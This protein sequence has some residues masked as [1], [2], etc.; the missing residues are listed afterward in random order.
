MTMP[1]TPEEYSQKS[2][3]PRTSL[4][5][6][7]WIL[8]E[9]LQRRDEK[10]ARIYVGSL[11]ILES[12]NANKLPF[13][14]HGI[15]E[16][17]T[18]LPL[19]LDVEQTAHNQSLMTRV[20]IIED[21]WKRATSKSDCHSNDSWNGN[22]NPQ[23]RKFMQKMRDF[24]NWMETHM[25]RRRLEVA[26]TL[27]ALDPAR[28]RLPSKLEAQNVEIWISMRDFFIG[29]AHHGLETSEEDFR[30]RLDEFERF[31]IERLSPRTFDD[32]TELDDVISAG[33]S[34]G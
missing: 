28:G 30:R 3:Y 29:V 26:D 2:D 17:L 24:F 16:I 11:Q 14:A 15:R 8:Y 19:C 12:S 9:S 21:E 27:F 22:T 10:I 33:E 34:N 5:E 23:L 1:S 13:A 32:A 7:Q 25:P 6:Q 20:R 4:G 18:K 31:L